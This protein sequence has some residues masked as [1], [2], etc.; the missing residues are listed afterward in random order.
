[1]LRLTLRVPR[2]KFE[3][4]PTEEGEA[5]ET[6]EDEQEEGKQKSRIAKVPFNDALLIAQTIVG[7]EVSSEIGS[8]G[9]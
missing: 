4:G 9:S 2:P 3:I 7:A 8:D 5:E 1:L 6:D